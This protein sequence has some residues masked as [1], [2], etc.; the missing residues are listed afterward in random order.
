MRSL[1]FSLFLLLGVLTF[2]LSSCDAIGGIFK[3]GAYTGIIGVVLIIALVIFVI[4]KISGGGN[5]V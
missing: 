1:R 3:A 4:R 2:S 5:N